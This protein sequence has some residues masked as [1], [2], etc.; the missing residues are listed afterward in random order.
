[1]AGFALTEQGPSAANASAGQEAKKPPGDDD[2]R[3][4]TVAGRRHAWP[5][6]TEGIPRDG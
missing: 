5:P 3:W 4:Q 1:M 2:G 6:R